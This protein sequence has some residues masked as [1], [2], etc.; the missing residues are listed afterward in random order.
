MKNEIDSTIK[1]LIV[2]NVLIEEFKLSNSIND[3]MKN[4]GIEMIKSI[5][6]SIM[7]NSN[8]AE[9]YS[10]LKLEVIA[11]FINNYE[12]HIKVLQMA[13]GYSDMADINKTMSEKFFDAESEVIDKYEMD[14][15]KREDKS[16]K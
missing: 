9:I 16:H 8:Y 5:E 14:S 12:H 13:K 3:I 6:D 2:L 10:D 7:D 15:E 4:N 11:D 1:K